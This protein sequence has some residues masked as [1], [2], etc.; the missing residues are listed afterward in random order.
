MPA[1]Y[2][3]STSMALARYFVGW[4]VVL[5]GQGCGFDPRSGHIQERT[6]DASISG[7]TN[8]CFFLSVS[9]SV[10][11]FLSLKSINKHLKK[12]YLL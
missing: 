7:T 3:E 8:Q 11:P 5:M 10:S 1:L 12:C 2:Y 6:R 9:L 4:S